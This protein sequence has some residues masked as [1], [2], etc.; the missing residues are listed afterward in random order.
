[1][2]IPVNYWLGERTLELGYPW[3]TPG[4]IDALDTLLQPNHRVL[5]FGSGGSTLYFGRRAASVLSFETVPD[6]AASVR[7]A[8]RQQSI[9]GVEVCDVS[10]ID[11]C[12]AVI[13]GRR[14]DVVL[15]DAN[16]LARHELVTVARAVVDPGGMVIIDNYNSMGTQSIDPRLFRGWTV[17]SFNDEHWRGD[18][19][20]IYLDGVHDG[21]DR[22]RMAPWAMTRN[23]VYR[24]GKV[25]S[26]RSKRLVPLRL[27]TWL[28]RHVVEGSRARR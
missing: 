9:E 21:F 24:V 2:L 23:V 8:V 15:V 20:R 3:I 11:E 16:D 10:S 18:G 25:A 13:G 5:E 7:D 26:P 4:S 22:V 27:K 6:W 19:T 14:F 28:Y 17:A 1:V 12:R